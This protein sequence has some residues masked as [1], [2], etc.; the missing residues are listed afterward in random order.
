MAAALSQEELAE[1]AG[2]SARGIS[3]LERGVSQ[4][5]RPETLRL[6]VDALK[7]GDRDREMLFA[8]ARVGRR[9]TTKQRQTS[10]PTHSPLL[11]GPLFGRDEERAAL[12]A[13]LI[14]PD[15]QLVTVT[16]MGGTGKTHLAVDVAS[17]LRDT[18]RDGVLFVDLAPIVD[19]AHVMPA[20][21]SALGIDEA[22]G[23]SIPE[24]LV[25]SLRERQ[26]LI[27]LDNCEQVVEAAPQIGQL[28]AACSG[29]T[30]LAT[31]REALSLR[32]ER[33]WPLLPLPVPN[34]EGLPPFA[35]L[36]RSPSVELFA[37]RAEANN[38]RFSLTVENAGAVA[39]I[40]HR[41]DGLPL[42]I[43][44]AAARVKLLTPDE[45]ASRLDQRLPL[46]T[47]GARDAPARQR[48]LRDAI[49]WSYDLLTPQEQALFRRLGVFVGGWTINAAE[50]VVD[51]S[52]TLD[53]LDGLGSLL[54][55]SLVRV[56]A[57]G[58]ESRYGMLET[59]RE[60]AVEQLGRQGEVEVARER[61][62]AYF[63]RLAERGAVA[64]ESL[65]QKRWLRLL[66]REH[67]NFREA[68][69]TLE[70]SGDDARY[71]RLAISLSWFWFF[72]THA[73]EGL[74][75]LQRVLAH[76][77]GDTVGRLKALT[78][79]GFLAYA[80]GDYANAERWLQ[81]GEELSR[82]F[83]E[84]P[85]LANTLLIRGTVR[86]HL[87]DEPGAEFYFQSGLAV[88]QETGDA[89]L[90]GEILPNLSDAAYRRGDVEL[91]ERFALDAFA[92][93]AES[94]NAYMESMNLGNVAQVALAQGDIERATSALRNALRIAEEIESRWN[95]ANAIAGAAAVEVV[96][97]RHEPAARLLG[98]ADAAR[99]ASGHP[100]LPAFY[101]FE[102]NQEAVQGALGPDRFRESWEAG[103][104]L[105][106]EDAVDEAR[107]VFAEADG[108]V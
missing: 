53:V 61:H 20:I 31:S 15:V 72:H 98:A 4:A 49:A 67:P 7:P 14:R 94:G 83:A 102:Q 45:L 91:A 47:G 86:E 21:A 40:C 74:Q 68:F 19:P 95:V 78:G 23:R 81:E 2:L 37:A 71:L 66:E 3:D 30:V 88:A 52:G 99:E 97:G 10:A 9:D 69:V 5:P 89:W 34:L 22:Q 82:V 36:R 18:F 76:E 73:A 92:P 105:S 24:A 101:L 55:K 79:A 13:L 50:V 96:R 87:G 35:D 80:V 93:L 51:P 70:Y 33:E 107:A 46:L 84:K 103:R 56:D 43:E 39:A 90:I 29:L 32:G 12:S 75:R 1:R 57:R 58:E 38:P 28:L 54:D 60:F 6:L 27:L 106:F 85:L 26:V 44:L 25:A 64:L 42:A 63:L 11:A 77:T 41:V 59:V 108:D 17:R 65:E 48:T 16:G 104:A 62:A 8:A 100:R